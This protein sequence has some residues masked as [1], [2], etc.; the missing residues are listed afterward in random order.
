MSSYCTVYPVNFALRTEQ[1]PLATLVTT[2]SHAS[3]LSINP[4]ELKPSYVSVDNLHVLQET[5]MGIF[6]RQ[7]FNSLSTMII[8]ASLSEPHTR[9]KTVCVSVRYTAIVY[10]K[11]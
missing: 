6:T 1:L 7:A 2:L 10:E 8:V 9:W 11:L 5:I 4:D 3:F